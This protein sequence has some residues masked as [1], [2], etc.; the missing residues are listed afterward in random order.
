MTIY[1]PRHKIITDKPE[2]HW[3][4]FLLSF[5]A[6]MLVISFGYFYYQIYSYEEP[7]V[8]MAS[9]KVVQIDENEDV[10]ATY[11]GNGLFY[12][13]GKDTDEYIIKGF[14]NDIVIPARDHVILTPYRLKGE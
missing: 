1:A 4:Q 2:P 14:N 9:V 5:V 7:V 10:I 11:F 6:G 3:W 13:F 8:S 12:A